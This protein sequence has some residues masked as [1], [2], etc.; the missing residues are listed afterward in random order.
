M[1]SRLSCSHMPAVEQN[2]AA[3]GEPAKS[4]S[5]PPPNSE[6]SGESGALLY[7]R[8]K[9]P[10]PLQTA[11][12]NANL[13][14]LTNNPAAEFNLHKQSLN[15]VKSLTHE[16][17]IS[18]IKELSPYLWQLKLV[19]VPHPPRPEDIN[20]RD[21]QRP[22]RSHQQIWNER[23]IERR[24]YAQ[25]MFENSKNYNSLGYVIDNKTS[26]LLLWQARQD[27]I[28]V[29]YIM[30]DPLSEGE[31]GTLMEKIVNISEDQ[32]KGGR[33]S[34]IVDNPDAIK[35]YERFGFR[36]NP[37]GG[38]TMILD[39]ADSGGKWEKNS[40]GEWALASYRDKKYIS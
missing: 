27:S 31:G 37:P 32:K 33:L 11:A 24:K 30:T 12:K 26:G 18:A 40:E 2:T 1:L 38:V 34:L 23:L 20:T 15:P 9:S 39:P 36:F 13:S 3:Q 14:K 16:E 5:A 28:Y 4:S 8:S 10:S 22:Q 29:G 21:W 35:T 25:T 7:R 19:P 17:T 6:R